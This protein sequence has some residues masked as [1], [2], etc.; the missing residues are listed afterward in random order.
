M[1]HTAPR[2]RWH[3]FVAH[4]SAL[5]ILLALIPAWAPPVQAVSAGVVISQVY[6]GGG[7]SGSTWKN[8]FVELFNRGTTPVDI[9]GWSVQYA[10]AAGSSWQVTGLS[11]LLWPGR[12]YLVQESQGTGGTTS[13]PAPDAFG[14]I[15]MSATAGKVAL[16]NNTTKLDGVCGSACAGAAGVVD[17][18]GFGSANSA[19][20]SPTPTLSNT[21]AA[22]RKGA[23]CTETDSNAADFSVGAPT[24]RNSKALPHGCG[25][26][27][28]GF[29]N[30]DPAVAA[31][32]TSSLLT[33]VVVPAS[34]STGITAVADLSSIGGS[35]SQA[36][37]DAGTGGDASTG[38]LIFSY[39]ATIPFSAPFGAKSLPVT[40]ADAQGHTGSVSIALTLE[41]DSAPS[42]LSTTPADGAGN[43][44]ID[45]LLNIT[46][47]EK[48]NVSAGWYSI[49]C[50][51][52]GVHSAT[53]SGGPVSF[54]LTPDAN[55]APLE[56]CSVTLT[57]AAV[58]DQDISD[59]PDN[60]AADYTFRFTTGPVTAIHDIQGAGH[61]SPL[62][63]QVVAY[64]A[65]IV[66]AKR[67]TGFYL[68]DPNPDADAATSEGIFVFTASPPTVSVGDAVAV[69]GTVTEFYPASNALPIT[70]INSPQVRRKSGGNPLPAPVLIGAGGRTPPTSVIED[71]A[72]GG[73]LNN[74]G[75]FDPA[76]DG[77]D[78]WE[79][80]EGM[81]VQVSDPV[82]VGPTN[83]FG[84]LPVVADNGAGAGP[85][86]ARGGVVATASDGNPERIF[87]DDQIVHPM[88]LL[89]VGDRLSGPV[90]GVMDYSFGNYMIELTALPG[91]VIPGGLTRETTAAPG[92][93]Q[94]A[95]AT[96]NVENLAPG[97]AASK[98]STLAGMIVTNLQSPDI[99]AVEEVQ[100]NS[101]AADTGVVD[102]SVTW[103]KLISVIAAAGGPSYDYRQV[104]PVNDQDGGA[105][106]GNIR[107]GF[108]FRTDRGLS[109]VDRPGAG[110]T[111]AN[112]V[113]IDGSG[114]HLQ[115]SPG[116]VAPTNAAWADSRKPLAAEFS[117]RG[118]QL[119]VVAN[120]FRSKGGDD[121]LFGHDQ[122][123]IQSSEPGRVQQAMVLHDF[124]TS[125]LSADPNA[126]LA[127]VGDMNDYEY[128][129][130]MTTLR[131]GI[132]HDPIETL[133]QGERYTYVF[134]GNSQALDH[135]M[136]GDNLFSHAS[137]DYDIVHVNS[138]FAD[139]ASDH[140]PQVVRLTLNPV[141][142]SAGGPYSVP[143]GGAVVLTG[144]G[145]SELAGVFNYAWDLDNDGS[146]E[147]NGQSVTFSAA[148][149]DGPETQTVGLRACH[150]DGACA[151]AST[152]VSI[153]N[154]A[155]SVGPV[156]GPT[157]PLMAGG[158]VNIAAAF[159][160]PGTAD[161]HA[162]SID[163]GDGSSA[164]S[165]SESGGSGTVTGSHIYMDGGL[166][167][168]T[169][170]VTDDD[171]GSGQATFRYVIVEGAANKVT[172]G[173]W[174]ST[175]GGKVNFGLNAGFKKGSTQPD[176]QTQVSGDGIDFHSSSY[177]YLVVVGDTAWYAGTGTLG[178]TGSYSFLVTV[179]DGGNGGM[180]DMVRIKI[181]DPSNGNVILDTQPGDPDDA[182]PT[183][184]LGGGNLTIHK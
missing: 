124:L 178:G 167:T 6:G 131:S 28:F 25:T 164:G 182:P 135:I 39:T 78:F 165:V 112:S 3:H 147:T 141:T 52:S 31:P 1:V 55:F 170:T 91:P 35:A 38:D 42:V 157:A 81:L 65:G 29:G 85:R 173:G 54:T 152:T 93:N 96:F 110:S 49:A 145:S 106:G 53:V 12:Y 59:P 105:P 126:L 75:L 154:V 107:V 175:P 169:V 133:P 159:S 166:Y 144:S 27:L 98:Y 140:E 119:F 115:Y 161:T 48:V 117:F 51:T 181:W 109:F 23:G 160:D 99:V 134:E 32:L 156:S 57:A 89:N 20:G 5:L 138:E 100:D 101:G 16:V 92:A 36:F 62:N 146:Y 45:A 128:S 76:N 30:A 10:S 43:V 150:S 148:G 79:S 88:P 121:P 116:R 130:S 34:N 22:L 171:G 120:H 168:V 82:A 61:L 15:A 13:L 58:A 50:A 143:E 40:L 68:Q 94:L 84:E 118:H 72:V 8:D 80:L 184:V 14:S 153:D 155:P 163:W 26:T 83:A 149:R 142:T 108:L 33:V 90:V 17:F 56:S 123:P 158:S 24:P 122:P 114:V 71:D 86:S 63:G 174:V 60:L 172:G 176:G 104:D 9:T 64:T 127:V 21:N 67:N 73:D 44:A 180:L 103:G 129:D 87:L 111:T 19:E 11:G 179:K 95:I 102:A 139:Q 136:L 37:S 70:E 74:G 162:A 183:S 47:S 66:T 77:A 151:T 125:L 46:F 41:P 137:F 7:N 97:D 69:G 2:G 113:V 132:L 18:V 4:L 177:R